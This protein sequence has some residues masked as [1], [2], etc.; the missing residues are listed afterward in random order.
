MYLHSGGAVSSFQI[1]END[2]V[3]EQEQESDDEQQ[4]QES[5]R[6]IESN[7]QQPL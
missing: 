5:E 6:N 1:Q 3:R 2:L 4:G 7:S